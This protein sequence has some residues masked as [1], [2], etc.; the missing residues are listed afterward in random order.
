MS[1]VHRREGRVDIGRLIKFLV[2]RVIV[3]ELQLLGSRPW[4]MIPLFV[5]VGME[6]GGTTC[7]TYRHHNRHHNAQNKKS[8]NANS[9]VGRILDLCLGHLRQLLHGGISNAMQDSHK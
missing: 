1:V 4:Q 3:I 8:G 6:K 7:P 2:C 9:S 5:I